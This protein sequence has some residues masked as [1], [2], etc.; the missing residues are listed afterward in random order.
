MLE[1]AAE[2]AVRREMRGDFAPFTLP[3][4]YRV[5]FDLRASYPA[6]YVDGVAAL[7]DFRLEKTG[8]RSFRFVTDDAKEIGHLLNAI[9]EVVLR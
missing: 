9:E 1:E 6:E 5:E 7:A 3:K 4:P 2:E 8:G